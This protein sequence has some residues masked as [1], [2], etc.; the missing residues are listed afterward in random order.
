LRS[1]LFSPTAYKWENAVSLV[2]LNVA[3]GMYPLA[4]M[5]AAGLVGE[6]SQRQYTNRSG[7]DLTYVEVDFANYLLN[8]TNE[9]LT[10]LAPFDA[11]A[12]IRDPQGTS[13]PLNDPVTGAARITVNPGDVLQL[14]GGGFTIPAGAQPWVQWDIQ[15]TAWPAGQVGAPS[16]TTTSRISLRYTSNPQWYARAGTDLSTVGATNQYC[17]DVSSIRARTMN[18]FALAVLGDSW[19]QGAG[20]GNNEGDRMTGFVPAACT[21][22]NGGVGVPY[23][24][25]GYT[26][27]KLLDSNTAA[28]VQ[29]RLDVAAAACTDVLIEFGTNDLVA[30]GVSLASMQAN[31]VALAQAIVDRGMRAHG[32]TVGPRTTSTDSWAT[33]AN[34]TVSTGYVADSNGNSGS[35]SLILNEFNDW[36]RTVPAPL[37]DVVEAADTV[38]SAHNS[39]IWNVGDGT[40]TNPAFT[41]D[42]VHPRPDNIGSRRGAVFQIA[43][44][45]AAKIDAWRLV[46]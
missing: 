21:Y 6:S 40:Y 31:Y 30:A 3:G 11:E 9:T 39:R 2:A 13:Y 22:A 26:G 37:T 25:L 16:Q 36:L 45:V 19:V 44:A 42:G 43:N 34:Q 33:T 20:D 5:R 17:Y 41:S 24:P 1:A 14:G 7:Y 23:M 15:G 38:M 12:A 32:F 29:H 28:K 18:R 27:T 46:S 4:Q 35:A 8:G 10:G